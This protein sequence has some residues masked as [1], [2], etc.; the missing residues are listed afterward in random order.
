M[1]F[2]RAL[3]LA[4]LV[5]GSPV[6]TSPRAGAST[7]DPCNTA[8]SGALAT[9][10]TDAGVYEIL[11]ATG[12]MRKLAVG[13]GAVAFHPNGRHFAFGIGDE[14]NG[15]ICL[16]D[17]IT[18][19]GRTIA[20][21]FRIPNGSN[22]PMQWVAQKVLLFASEDFYEGRSHTNIRRLDIAAGA[23]TTLATDVSSMAVNQTGRFVAYGRWAAEGGS[24][25]DLYV[26]FTSGVGGERH[27]FTNPYYG[28][29]RIAWSPDSRQIAI[30]DP[31]FIINTVTGESKKLLGCGGSVW[32]G[33]WSPLGN[34]FI[35]TVTS[36]TTDCTLIYDRRTDSTT[37]LAISGGG[38][39]AWSPT[40]S[41]VL[42]A[43]H[44]DTDYETAGL[45]ATL[46]E[47]T[48]ADGTR[49]V[50]AAIEEPVAR[51]Y[52]YFTPSYSPDGLFVRFGHVVAK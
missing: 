39:S 6:A 4:V 45:G 19:R 18:L 15:R 49:T 20:N 12:T 34:R 11:R 31:M 42:F 48:V 28:I 46:E 29:T 14:I 35:F 23:V 30:N 50:L 32:G 27:L 9:S 21:G 16:G 3:F 33:A 7:E 26:R 8:M 36:S 5:L 1:R 17:T 2:W 38:P 25:G 37:Q 44:Q 10:P 41:H 43:N 52:H 24:G 13:N 22:W 51:N 47:L 40:G